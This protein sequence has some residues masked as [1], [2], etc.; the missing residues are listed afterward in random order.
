MNKKLEC[1]PIERIARQSYFTWEHL[2]KYVYEHVLR[3]QGRSRCPE[4]ERETH[5]KTVR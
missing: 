3:M 4:E 1:T 2:R 5:H